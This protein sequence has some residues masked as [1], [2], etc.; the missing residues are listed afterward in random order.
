MAD[1][2]DNLREVNAL[3]T[4][5]VGQTSGTGLFDDILSTTGVSQLADQCILDLAVAL[6]QIES[7]GAS[8]SNTTKFVIDL[9]VTPFVEFGG[10]LES[11]FAPN[12]DLDSVDP[13]NDSMVTGMVDALG[14]SMSNPILAAVG[15]QANVLAVASNDLFKSLFAAPGSDKPGAVTETVDR[16]RYILKETIIDPTGQGTNLL[17]L[18]FFAIDEALP[19]IDNELIYLKRM[20]KALTASLEQTS[21]LPPSMVPAIPSLATSN[22]LCEVETH[23]DNVMN[24]LRSQ[25]KLDRSE[26]GQASQK[27][28]EA[29]DTIISG[30]IPEAFA[31]QLQNAFGLN[32]LQMNALRQARFMPDPKFRLRLVELLY[33]QNSLQAQDPAVREFH[34]NLRDLLNVAHTLTHLHIGD[35]LANIIEVLKRQI[36]AV[37]V[38]L[39]ADGAGFSMDVDW[40][41]LG[42]PS[43]ANG[44]AA[45]AGTSTAYKPN[46]RTDIY[47][48]ASTQAAAAAQLTALCFMM[49]RT[50]RLYAGVQRLLDINTGI[51]AQL[52]R[53]LASYTADDCGD[54]SGADAISLATRAY[55]KACEERLNGL[56]KTNAVVQQRA[57]ELRAA[58]DAHEKFLRCIRDRLFMGRG[59]LIS[60]VSNALAVYQAAKNIAALVRRVPELY[61]TATSLSVLTDMK[62][63]DKSYN[64]ADTIVKALQCLVLQ[65]NNPKLKDLAAGA[66]EYFEAEREAKKASNIT[67]RAL[68]ELPRHSRMTGLNDR[69]NSFFRLIRSLQRITSF[70]LDDMCSIDT[71][72]AP[73]PPKVLE[74]PVA[75]QPVDIAAEAFRASRQAQSAAGVPQDNVA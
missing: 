74:K 35:I 8:D 60:G 70:N 69:V 9:L 23:L 38:Q 44:N 66:L 10:L 7:S 13:I 21:K 47:S 26:F 54:Y 41:A 12:G 14:R 45:D 4:P 15:M 51:A 20:R 73:K 24:T 34:T 25:R 30:T 46:A 16:I 65:C 36:R 27:T 42:V 49:E 52:K 62:G 32:D 5:A 48:Y 19:A 28:C 75:P 1:A 56:T 64:A 57:K 71:T 53:F 43:P 59:K 61:K 68:S 72:G 40:N 31:R 11:T 17:G 3:M 29:R 6:T 55:L 50:T 33:Y 67:F 58:I 63:Q 18:V 37:R 2:F 39:E 22:L